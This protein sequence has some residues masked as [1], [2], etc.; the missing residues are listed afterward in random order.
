M[1]FLSQSLNLLSHG[2]IADWAKYTIGYIKR[3]VGTPLSPAAA[4]AAVDEID[5]FKLVVEGAARAFLVAKLGP[6]GGDLAAGIADHAVQA[7]ATTLESA[8]RALEAQT[9]GNAPRPPAG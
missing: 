2:D 3:R 5:G 7:V 8:T 9:A 6:F 1:S 4:E